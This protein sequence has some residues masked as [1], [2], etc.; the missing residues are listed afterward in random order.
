MK[1]ATVWAKCWGL[2]LADFGRNPCSTDSL[3]SSQNSLSGKWCTISPISR[4]INFTKFEQRRWKRSEQNFENFTISRRLSKKN[5]KM[6]TKFP[7]LAISG[8]HNSVMITDSRKFTSE[9]TLY[10]MSSFHFYRKELIRSISLGWPLATSTTPSLRLS[11]RHVQKQLHRSSSFCYRGLSYTALE[12]IRV[13]LKRVLSYRTFTQLSDFDK[14]WY[15]G[16]VQPSWASRPLKISNFKNPRWRRPPS[17][18]IDNRH[19]SAAV[20]P[21]LTQFGTMMHFEPLGRPEH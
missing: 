14:I 17:W 20:Q 13:S 1:S 11:R 9:L 7:C 15:D 6:I 19:I 12:G 18:K 5:K 10:G 4:R 16:A 3:R 2:A 21:I 8:C